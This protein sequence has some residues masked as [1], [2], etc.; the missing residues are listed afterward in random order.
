M[1]FLPHHLG[2]LLY[3]DWVLPD[4]MRLFEAT[5]LNLLTSNEINN[6]IIEVS[7]RHGKSTFFSVLFPTWYLLTHPH[8]KVIVCT[9]SGPFSAEL[10]G[11]IRDLISEYGPKLTG[12]RLDP[13][14]SARD[15]CKLSSPHSG[16][17]RGIGIGGSVAGKGADLL[18]IDDP[19]KDIEEVANPERRRK[20]HEWFASELKTRLSPNAKTIVVA[21]R[22]HPDDLSGRLLSTNAD[23]PAEAQWHTIRFPA[24]NESGEPLWPKRYSKE[25]LE[26]IRKEYEVNGLSYLWT[27]LWM[28]NPTEF[29]STEWPDSYIPPLLC[30]TQFTSKYSIIALDPSAGRSDTIGDYPALVY[31]VIDQNNDIWIMDALMERKPIDQVENVAVDWIEKYHP[32]AFI[33]ETNGFQELVAANIVRKCNSRNINCPLFKHD[34]RENKEV[35]IRLILT[36]LLAQGKI[37]L[38]DCPG[39]R[40]GRQQLKEFPTAAHD[41]YP[42]ALVI[43][44]ELAQK[45]QMI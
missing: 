41:D 9:Y 36:P 37:H 8:K 4:H 25:K 30:D 38:K 33:C 34:S 5:A 12:V 7:V 6:L 31:F 28:Q 11:K 35:R 27:S 32:N 42:D 18:I 22:R 13:R 19:V 1:E 14:Y 16:E 17:L 44:I 24:L 39:N 2:P 23:L 15:F 20:L 21:S 43:G 40:I 3:H 45:L 29:E 10:S 26:I